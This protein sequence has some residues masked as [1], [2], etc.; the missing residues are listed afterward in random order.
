M[1]GNFS[2]DHVTITRR[3]RF[4]LVERS[5]Y[6]WTPTI[7]YPLSS[8]KHGFVLTRHDSGVPDIE[9]LVSIQS[10]T[11]DHVTTI[12]ES[13]Y[14]PPKEAR[15]GNPTVVRRSAD[16]RKMTESGTRPLLA[17]LSSDDHQGALLTK[18]VHF[19]HPL[20]LIFQCLCDLTFVIIIC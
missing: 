9:L 19:R 15:V 10:E 17:G 18:K 14:R 7:E 4:S 3:A 11:A 12:P 2:L 5:T 20:P 1:L 16:Q 6:I 13:V 8:S